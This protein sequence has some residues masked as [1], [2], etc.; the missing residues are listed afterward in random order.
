M[1]SLAEIAARPP[2]IV[3]ANNAPRVRL[4]SEIYLCVHLKQIAGPRGLSFCE[5]G[6]LVAYW[7]GWFSHYAHQ[8]EYFLGEW[9]AGIARPAW[10]WAVSVLCRIDDA[11][12]FG[13]GNSM[14]VLG[15]CILE[16]N[17]CILRVERICRYSLAYSASKGCS[18][19]CIRLKI[20]E[21]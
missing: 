13:I 5:R 3:Y 9:W 15:C 20:P 1:S 21:I 19:F 18:P 4:T 11:L 10:G 14:K 2:F 16:S 12:Q 6:W 8:K 17:S 7:K